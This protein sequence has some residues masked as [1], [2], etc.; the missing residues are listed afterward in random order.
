[1]TASAYDAIREMREHVKTHT[2][3]TDV[4]ILEPGESLQ[5]TPPSA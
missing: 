3:G 1:V 4:R 2:R 5:V